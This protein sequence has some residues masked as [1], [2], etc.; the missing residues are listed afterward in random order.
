MTELCLRLRRVNCDINKTATRSVIKVC[1]HDG[2]KRSV[3]FK[4]RWQNELHG[5]K[6]EKCHRFIINAG[7][8]GQQTLWLHYSCIVKLSRKMCSCSTLRWWN[9]FTPVFDDSSPKPQQH[10]TSTCYWSCLPAVLMLSGI[11]IVNLKRYYTASGF[12]EKN[13]RFMA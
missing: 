3:L 5:S 4:E 9:V 6:L 7:F 13:S 2:A 1:G 8:F 11:E 12:S 10:Q